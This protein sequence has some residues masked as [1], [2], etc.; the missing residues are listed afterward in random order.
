[1]NLRNRIQLIGNLKGDLT[2]KK[3]ENG[4]KMVRFTITTFDIYKK[5]NVFEK[6][7]QLH[8]IL[9]WNKVADIAEKNLSYECEVII[10]GRLTQ[11]SYIDQNGIKQ[12]IVEVIAETIMTRSYQKDLKTIKN[13]N[14]KR[15]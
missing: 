6:N 13:I 11:R 12:N 14:K 3:F 1:M 15:A 2:V 5:E 7:I 8:S 10:D 4:I 9:A